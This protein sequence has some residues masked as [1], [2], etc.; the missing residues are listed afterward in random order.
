VCA[1]LEDS[2]N[3]CWIASRDIGAG[4]E[5]GAAIL[6]A[7]ESSDLMVLVFSTY[8]N[9]SPQVRR[10]IAHAARCDVPIRVIRV[11]SAEPSGSFRLLTNEF[12]AS[13]ET[14]LPFEDRL[15]ALCSAVLGGGA[16]AG[17]AEA[18]IRKPVSDQ[19]GSI[20]LQS[21]QELLA[22][23]LK[24]N[25]WIAGIRMLLSAVALIKYFAEHTGRDEA[26]TYVAFS[27]PLHFAGMAW[28]LA[29]FA[30]WLAS[31][32]HSWLA[33]RPTVVWQAFLKPLSF[34]TAPRCIVLELM[35]NMQGGNQPIAKARRWWLGVAGAASLSLLMLI[36]AGADDVH[37]L[38]LLLPDLLLT[39]IWF[40]TAMA[41]K[42][43][44][45]A[46]ETLPAAPKES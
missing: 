14:A 6:A 13:A 22:R 42:S 21:L 3:L 1:A 32:S 35:Q 23:V 44:V 34:M 30:V 12:M 40:P 7:I 36:L 38:G 11:D 43:V 26:R 45:L 46:V 31:A 24:V 5:W 4:Q 25:Y 10:E 16:Q 2:G 27:L 19:S 29:T 28:L 41:T 33:L 17:E 8:S 37:P 39:M 20:P 9:N 18:V 15:A